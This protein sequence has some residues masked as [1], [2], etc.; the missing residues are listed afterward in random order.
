[1]GR[2]RISSLRRLWLSLRRCR[3][4]LRRRLLPRHATDLDTL[5]LALAAGSGVLNHFANADC[6][7][8]APWRQKSVNTQLAAMLAAFWSGC[9]IAMVWST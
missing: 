6:D 1:M 3:L 8:T 7:L 9:R 5:G 2:I 4:G